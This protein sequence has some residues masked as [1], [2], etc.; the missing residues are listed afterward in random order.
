MDLSTGFYS[1]FLSFFFL[2]VILVFLAMPWMDPFSLV[3]E[4]LLMMLVVKLGLNLSLEQE[5]QH[6][7]ALG[8][9]LILLLSLSQVY[10]KDNLPRFHIGF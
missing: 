3:L 5:Q 8:A 4:F 7:M 6:C 9:A 2:V 1:L 10:E